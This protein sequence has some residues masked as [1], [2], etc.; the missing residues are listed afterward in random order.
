MDDLFSD[1]EQAT[2]M[3]RTIITQAPKLLEDNS[4]EI[5]LLEK[6]IMDIEHVLELKPFSAAKGYQYAKEI[7][8]A[9]KR[10]R[11]LKDQNELLKP[12]VE[13]I[14]RPKITENELNKAI[15]EIRRCKRLHENRTYKMRVREDLQGELSVDH[16]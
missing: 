8:E 6:E 7:R 5:T 11:L 9:R 13:V 2:M 10:R 15:G 14:R 4:E 16:G 3:L 1:I 12:L